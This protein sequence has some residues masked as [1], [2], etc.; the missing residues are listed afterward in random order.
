MSLHSGFLK[1]PASRVHHFLA[2]LANR[3]CRCLGKICP[4]LELF[5]QE[6]GRGG[7][8][9]RTGL[10]LQSKHDAA[11]PWSQVSDMPV[12]L[13]THP[14]AHGNEQVRLANTTLLTKSAQCQLALFALMP[15]VGPGQ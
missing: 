8:R 9:W 12:H 2:V 13:P 1:V 15:P 7:R 5:V 11:P 10:P 14:A 6:T 3:H 4:S